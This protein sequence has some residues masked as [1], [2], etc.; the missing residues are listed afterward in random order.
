MAFDKIT[1]DDTNGKGVVGLPD[2]PQLDT[3][4]MQK[5]FDEL[6]TDVIIPKFNK[7]VND[8]NGS[9]GAGSTGVKV[10]EGLEADANLQSVIQALHDD[11]QTRQP[12]EDGKGLSTNDYTNEEKEKVAENVKARHT[13]ENKNVLDVITDKVKAGYDRI[14]ILL[15]GIESV[16]NQVTS[17]EKVIPTGKAI[18]NYVQSMGG[19]DMSAS[20]YDPDGDGKV[21]W[22]DTADNALTF[23]GKSPEYYENPYREEN[24]FHFRTSNSGSDPPASTYAGPYSVTPQTEEQVLATKGKAM[25]KDVTVQEVPRHDVSNGSGTS[26]IIGG[27]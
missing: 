13:H 19:G 12:K 3:T 18:V 1:A 8:L 7:L 20:K 14:V 22:A 27:N 25:S 15:S 17:S 11:T 26:V 4:S 5:K 9:E 24:W 21:T 6:A 23:C 16:S 10:P 2:T